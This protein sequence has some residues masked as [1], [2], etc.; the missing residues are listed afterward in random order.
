MRK[1]Q[2]AFL[3]TVALGFASVTYTISAANSI[4]KVSK[5]YSGCIVW[6]QKSIFMVRCLIFLATFLLFA[7]SV[8]AQEEHV[9][10]VK[11]FDC[12]HQPTQRSQTGFRV[13]GLK[14]I[15]TALHGVADCRL[16]TASSKRGP[17]LDQPLTIR[18][19]DVDHDVALLSSSQLDTMRDEGFDVAENIVWESLKSVKVYGHPYGISNLDTTLTVRGEPLKPLKELIPPDTLPSLRMR[20]SPNYLINVLNLQGNLLP[21]HSG[22][23]VLDTSGRLV[24][25]AN[26]GLK[27]G[28]ASISWGIPYK[29]ITWDNVSGRLR[30]LA[31]ADPNILFANDDTLAEP[32]GDDLGNAFCARLSELATAS[33]AGFISIIGE[34]ICERTINCFKPTIELPGAISRVVEPREYVTYRLYDANNLGKIESQYYK[35]IATLSR[36][37][38]SWKQKQ[39]MPE[40]PVYSDRHV[41][42]PIAYKRYLLREKNNGVTIEVYYDVGLHLPT[43]NRT[44]WLSVYAPG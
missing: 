39:Q 21:G 8:R 11:M 34:T 40:I 30:E 5:L 19:I 37:F 33:H 2:I 17:I 28:L 6:S 16:I 4:V 41:L 38:P 42:Q 36:C 10:L 35:F 7:P 43:Y 25:V 23:P 9:Y 12:V 13:R 31:Q 20:N 24:A 3:I 15:V 44:L 32:R 14:G 27:G 26:G 18:K 22:A 1:I 29:N